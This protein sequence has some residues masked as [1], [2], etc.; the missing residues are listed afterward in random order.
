M[1][2]VARLSSVSVATVSAV[3][4]GKAGVSAAVVAR[5]QQAMDAL[6]YHPDQVA[7]SLRVRRTMTIGIVVPE[8]T[9]GFFP[10]V[11]RG[12]EGAARAAGYAV[13]LCNSNYDVALEQL[14][15]NALFSRR[16]DGVL[17][18]TT[19]PSSFGSRFLRFGTP[20]VLLDRLPQGYSGPAVVI[21]NKHAA[22]EATKYL[23]SIGHHR[24][25]FI[26]GPLDISTGFDRAEGFRAAMADSNLTVRGEYVKQG[27][28]R[29]SG[30]Y[31]A[32]LELLRL[33]EPPTAVFSSSSA[34][35]LGVAKA[36]KD[37]GVRCPEDL[38]MIGFEPFPSVDGLNM[39]I[40][41]APAL[42][43]ISQPGREMGRRATEM[44]LKVVA[45]SGGGD[46]VKTEGTAV[47]KSELT[48]RNSV[49][50]P[51]RSSAKAAVG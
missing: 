47:F 45:D 49:A 43:V 6:N 11:V 7:R 20:V 29:L 31:Q 21:D 10:E 44:L 1:R 25:A 48:F 18:A 15:L 38:S 42:T 26:A 17:L 19:D 2:D 32:G 4:N 41:M 33:D 24:I 30:G 5:V 13:L 3:V 35:T 36:I 28:F 22:Y 14:Q 37:L 12:A 50:P 51:A 9:G 27:N 16:V 39:G 34:M 8:I 40:L 23:I 46:D